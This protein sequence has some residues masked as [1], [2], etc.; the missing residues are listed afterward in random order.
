VPCARQKLAIDNRNNIGYN[1]SLRL[2]L[3]TSIM[4]CSTTPMHTVFQA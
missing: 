4:C 1:G 3:H 2:H